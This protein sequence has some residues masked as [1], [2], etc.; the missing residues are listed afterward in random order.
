MTSPRL[1]QAQISELRTAIDRLRSLDLA[2][3]SIDEIVDQ[4]VIIFRGWRVTLPV[5]EPGLRLF[6]GTTRFGDDQPANVT[7]FSYPPSEICR[8]NRANR[9][10]SPL[11]YCSAGRNAV[12]FELNPEEG[13]RLAMIHYETTRRLTANQV[14]FTDKTFRQL[15]ASRTVPEYGHLNLDSYSDAD[16]L[17]RDFLSE[18]FCQEVATHEAWRYKLSAAIAEKLLGRNSER[19]QGLMYPTIP[20]WGNADNFALRPD[21]ADRCLR[22][23]YAELLRIT[24]LRL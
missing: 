14:G 8:L 21:Y 17:I 12:V 24:K 18:V 16:F 15:A 3:I 22:P 10:A 11:L 19:I 5:F 2:E 9:E 13:S 23:V 4:L 20:M 1:V 7:D 6:R